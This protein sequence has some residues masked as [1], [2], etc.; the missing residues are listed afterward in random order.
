MTATRRMSLSV[1]VPSAISRSTTCGETCWP[2]RL[3]MRSRAVA[4]LMLAS[5]CR[6]NCMPDRA[7]QHAADQDDQAAGG[8]IED[9]G[10]GIVAAG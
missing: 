4:A 2:N 6:R 7:R 8:V 9:A 1:L 10:L 3:V 5:N